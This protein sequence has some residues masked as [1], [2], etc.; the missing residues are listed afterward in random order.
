M[1]V[2]DR[3]GSMCD[4]ANSGGQCRDM[5]N[6]VNG[7]KTFLGFMDP[8]LDEVGMTVFP[9]ALD[10]SS[11]CKTPT[12][13]ASNYGYDAWWPNWDLNGSRGATP[14]LYAVVS[15]DFNY[16]RRPRAAGC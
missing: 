8:T 6:V 3:T 7:I 10:K 15:P 5:T 9:P 16:L 14:N 13:G 4:V 12:G 1:L 2:V 11:V